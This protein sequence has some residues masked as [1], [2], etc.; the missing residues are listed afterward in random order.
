MQ[1][2]GNR[3]GFSS[4]HSSWSKFLHAYWIV[5]SHVHV[6]DRSCTSLVS[7]SLFN[8]FNPDPL[9]YNV[10]QER[11]RCKHMTLS[12]KTETCA[13]FFSFMNKDSG[14]APNSIQY[15]NLAGNG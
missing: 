9:I 4:D 5:S 2:N 10:Y 15:H 6:H 11:N 8:N 3:Q 7:I 14:N 13:D 12:Y 1:S